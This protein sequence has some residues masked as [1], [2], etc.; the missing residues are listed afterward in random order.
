MRSWASCSRV[1]SHSATATS[2]GTRSRAVVLKSV[3][4]HRGARALGLELLNI[5]ATLRE[6]MREVTDN[7]EM[8]IADQVEREPAAILRRFHQVVLVQPQPGVPARRGPARR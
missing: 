4:S 3:P 2:R 5:D 8:I 7:P 6:R 1:T